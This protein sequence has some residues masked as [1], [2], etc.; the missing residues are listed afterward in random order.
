MTYFQ[1]VVY[2][3]MLTAAPENVAAI[4]NANLPCLRK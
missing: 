4:D 3:P 1:E 2:E